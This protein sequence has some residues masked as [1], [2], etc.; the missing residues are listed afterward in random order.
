MAGKD[1]MFGR[2]V[3]M[4]DVFERYVARWMQ[5]KLSGTDFELMIKFPA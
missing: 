2:F 4:N 3:R 1:A 5:E